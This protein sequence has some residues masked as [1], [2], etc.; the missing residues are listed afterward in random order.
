MANHECEVADFEH[1]KFIIK[2]DFAI[3]LKIF[4]LIPFAGKI[5]YR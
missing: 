1:N 5:K 4:L 3:A 2:N